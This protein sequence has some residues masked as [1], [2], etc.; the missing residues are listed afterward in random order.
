MAKVNTPTIKAVQ[1][2]SRHR[3]DGNYPIVIR[4]QFNGRAERYLPI[5]VPKSQWDSKN[6]RVK[7]T[8]VSWIAH[9]RLITNELHKIEMK[10]FEYQRLNTPFTAK[11]LLSDEMPQN[12]ANLLIFKDLMEK[13]LKV[14]NYN[15]HTCYLYHYS[16]DVLVAYMGK[17]E[18]VKAKSIME[19]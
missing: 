11:M 2:T 4:V 8:C 10:L 6:G 15:P 17:E 16:Y 19:D 13:M 5:A 1:I 18:L 9:N 3:A 12:N 14:K 7:K